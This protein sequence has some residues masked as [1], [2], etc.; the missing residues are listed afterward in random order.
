[1]IG[2]IYL[3]KNYPVGPYIDSTGVPLAEASIY[4]EK[5]VHEK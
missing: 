1:M 3:I 4:M 5:D 2:I